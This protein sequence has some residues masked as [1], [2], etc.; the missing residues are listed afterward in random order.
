M[1]IITTP[2]V[3]AGT[4]TTHD[5]SDYSILRMLYSWPI[6]GLTSRPISATVDF[7]MYGSSGYANDIV[8][9]NCTFYLFESTESKIISRNSGVYKWTKVNNNR[10]S[11]YEGKSSLYFSA[12]KL[13][14]FYDN[15]DPNRLYFTKDAPLSIKKS[16]GNVAK[17][18]TFNFESTQ[19]NI[20]LWNGS[21]MFF[22]ITTSGAITPNYGIKQTFKLTI[23]CQDGSIFHYYNNNAWNNIKSVKYYNGTK[24]VPIKSVTYYPP[25]T[26][27]PPTPFTSNSGSDGYSCSASTTLNNNNNFGAWRAFDGGV[28]GDYGWCSSTYDSGDSESLYLNLPKKAYVKT[29]TIQNRASTSTPRGPIKAQILGKVSS[30]DTT[31]VVLSELI[32]DMPGDTSSASTTINITQNLN[33]AVQQIIIRFFDWQGKGAVSSTTQDYLGIG[34]V[35]AQ[36]IYPI[37]L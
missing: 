28:N 30:S 10:Y 22:G 2:H 35:S 32:E 15:T 29:V 5:S 20:D 7:W 36:V 31:E 27:V 16:A 13:S 25:A 18:V 14:N 17:S 26:T 11:Q 3:F 8:D 1:A 4:G 6:S 21:E 19:Q 34:E 37:T 33:T 12:D 23:F 9:Q 24:W